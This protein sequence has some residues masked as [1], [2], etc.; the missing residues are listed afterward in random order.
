MCGKHL[1]QY[2]HDLRVDDEDLKEDR[3]RLAHWQ[4]GIQQ[5]MLAHTASAKALLAIAARNADRI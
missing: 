4:V 1:R 2:I 5:E 3:D